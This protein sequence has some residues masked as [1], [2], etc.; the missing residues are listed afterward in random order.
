MGETMKR[1]RTAW[2]R[3]ALAELSQERV[4]MGQLCYGNSGFYR[5]IHGRPGMA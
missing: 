3:V 4:L 5:V 1:D 2:S